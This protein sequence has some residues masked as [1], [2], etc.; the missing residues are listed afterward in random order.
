[1]VD[2]IDKSISIV[3]V[4]AQGGNFIARPSL[5]PSD[6]TGQ[7]RLYRNTIKVQV[8]TQLRRD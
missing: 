5:Q 3:N 2:A 4:A 6:G 7:R 8:W 1:V